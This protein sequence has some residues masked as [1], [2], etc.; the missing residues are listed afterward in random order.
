MLDDA[1]RLVAMTGPPRTAVRARPSGSWPTTGSTASHHRIFGSKPGTYG[2][3][4]AAAASTAAA[5]DDAD[6]A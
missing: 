1:V 4:A 2:A 3:G 6:L 5:G